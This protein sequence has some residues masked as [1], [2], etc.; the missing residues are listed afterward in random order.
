VPSCREVAK[1]FLSLVDEDTGD[2]ITN[3]KLQKLL[4]YAQGFHLAIYGTELFP[5]EI[6]AW[7]YGPVVPKLYHSLKQQGSQ[8][9]SISGSELPTRLDIKTQRFLN[10]VYSVYGQFS[11]LKLMKMTHLEAPWRDT[12]RGEVITHS[13][14]KRYFK[15]RLVK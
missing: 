15:T 13:S 7:E 9:I 8:P 2:S 4:Y 11:A 1:Y 5:E 14:M 12:P 6:E 10:E 3:L